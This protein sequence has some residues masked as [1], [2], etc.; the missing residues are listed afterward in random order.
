MKISLRSLGL[1]LLSVTLAAATEL[2]QTAFAAEQA[3]YF[4]NATVS[5]VALAAEP[6]PALTAEELPA[7]DT[8]ALGSGRHDLQRTGSLR[9]LVSAVTELPSLEMNDEMRCL[10]TAVYFES[11]GEPLEGQ[12]AVAQVILNRVQQRWAN[13]I[14]G[15]VYQPRQF[16]FAND[17]QSDTPRVK[18]DWNTAKAVAVIAAAGEW[19]EI[20]KD[21]TH[22][23]AARVAPGWSNLVRISRYGNHV[24][25][26]QR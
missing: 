26:R 23:H 12:L 17:G 4:D 18:H 9:Q 11:R 21:A 24:F 10:A 8:L 16:S 25:Y 3:G 22:F 19:Q 15:V 7:D 13:S 5:A 2:P 20:A 6:G 14:C 1:A